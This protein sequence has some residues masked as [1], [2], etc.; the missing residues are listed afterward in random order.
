M[1]VGTNVWARRVT[2]VSPWWVRAAVGLRGCRCVQFMHLHACPGPAGQAQSHS[3][4]VAQLSQ[5][6][7]TSTEV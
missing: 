3:P 6:V 2:G 1:S 5:M 7:P 4:D